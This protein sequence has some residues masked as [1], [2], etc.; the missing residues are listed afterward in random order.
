MNYQGTLPSTQAQDGTNQAT[1]PFRHRMAGSI[2]FLLPSGFNLL[3]S[4]GWG[5]HYGGCCGNA[6]AARQDSTTFF[7]KAGYQAKIFGFGPSNFA[8]EGGQTF[9]RIQ[10]GDI[11]SRY[12]LSFDQQVITKGFEVFAG[13]EHLT[14][15][16]TGTVRLAPADLALV[17]S[18]LQF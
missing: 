10:D 14:L 1:T 2:A 12:G 8:V 6:V 11:A 18:R 5:E 16:R 4:A 17:G 15:H 7:L 9:N 3:A 13:Y